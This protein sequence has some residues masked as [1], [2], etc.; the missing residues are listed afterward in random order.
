MHN[1]QYEIYD[2]H[3]FQYHQ[4][5]IYNMIYLTKNYSVAQMHF[6][7]INGNKFSQNSVKRCGKI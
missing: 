4:I 1:H 3:T 6:Q 2:I 7:R 5:C